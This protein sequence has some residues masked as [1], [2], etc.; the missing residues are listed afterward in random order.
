[1]KPR[2]GMDAYC[3][4]ERLSVKALRMQGI[5][6][7]LPISLSLN[8]LIPWILQKHVFQYPSSAS[9]ISFICLSDGPCIYA[10]EIL[11]AQ[12]FVR[13]H[14]D[15]NKQHLQ[16]EFL[17][18]AANHFCRDHPPQ[19]Y[20]DAALCH[21]EVRLNPKAIVPPAGNEVW[22]LLQSC[23]CQ[24]VQRKRIIQEDK[25]ASKACKMFPAV[26]KRSQRTYVCPPQVTC[27]SSS[28]GHSRVVCRSDPTEDN[29]MCMLLCQSTLHKVSCSSWQCMKQF[30]VRSFSSHW[31]FN[32]SGYKQTSCQQRP[33]KT[34]IDSV[35]N[36]QMESST[37]HMTQELLILQMQW[38]LSDL[39][40][41]CQRLVLI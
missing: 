37:S 10:R 6:R 33:H 32:L 39:T 17:L 9:L 28:E 24:W 16:W 26:L 5:G 2:L 21:R 18:Q 35:L 30:R 13:F 8:L 41:I 23:I 3:L 22:L 11:A 29:D 40:C 34:L 38:A 7:A 36:V 27:T 15:F 31:R 25:I 1:M 19:K 14:L 20:A 4:S 12:N